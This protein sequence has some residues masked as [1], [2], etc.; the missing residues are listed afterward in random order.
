MNIFADSHHEELCSALVRLF[1]KRLGH[2][3]YFPGL[4]EDGS[5]GW[6]H[7]EDGGGIMQWGNPMTK[8]W[9]QRAFSNRFLVEDPGYSTW[10]ESYRRIPTYPKEKIDFEIS[11]KDHTAVGYGASPVEEDI[12]AYPVSFLEFQDLQVDL[13]LCTCTQNM[14]TFR[15][16]RDL[17]PNAKMA[18]QAGNN[19]F[20]FDYDLGLNLMSSATIPYNN[21]PEKVHKVYYW[22]EFDMDLRFV[23]IG[24]PKEEFERTIRCYQHYIQ[25]LSWFHNWEKL[26]SSVNAE[27][28]SHGAGNDKD[29]SSLG[30]SIP[31]AIRD[32]VASVHSKNSDGYGFN[33]AHSL[34]MGR[35]IIGNFSE[36]VG[37]TREFWLRPSLSMLHCDPCDYV[38]FENVVKRYIDSS[39]M[40]IDMYYSTIYFVR[41]QFDFGEEASKVADWLENLQ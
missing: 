29:L 41:P 16:L 6:F 13:L 18:Y 20:V 22:Q 26:K 5:C 9:V 31:F 38:D 2:K 11:E 4:G 14:N 19:E 27:L 33:I 17:K 3:L 7:Y 12:G 37:Q 32:S 39:Q 8:D 40:K 23:D 34:V 25:T 1:C 28:I 15:V 35:P 21:A 30:W 10:L 24:P 36:C